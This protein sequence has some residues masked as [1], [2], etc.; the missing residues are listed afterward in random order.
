MED[1]LVKKLAETYPH[2]IEEP[3]RDALLLLAENLSANHLRLQAEEY[4]HL[5]S[6]GNWN[7]K[8]VSAL[9][10]NFFN[11]SFKF[12]ETNG[13]D[14]VQY[15]TLT[16]L[17]QRHVELWNMDIKPIKESIERQ[18]KLMQPGI[19]PMAKA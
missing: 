16:N 11:L 17:Y 9:L 6:E 14:K 12:F 5:I 7:Y 10:N 13:I 18:Q 19:A 8:Q 4:R 1:K 15:I 2:K 3:F